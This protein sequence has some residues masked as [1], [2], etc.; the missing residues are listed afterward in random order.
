MLFYVQSTFSY[1]SLCSDLHTSAVASE[2]MA[3]QFFIVKNDS[4]LFC[5]GMH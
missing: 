3:K 1:V 4:H 5:T 2:N